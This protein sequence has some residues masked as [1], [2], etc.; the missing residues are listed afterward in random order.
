M[1]RATSQRRSTVHHPGQFTGD[2]SH[3]TGLPAIVSAVARGDCEVYEILRGRAAARSEPV[4]DRQRHHPAG[5]HRAAAASARVSQLHGAARDRF[6]LLAGHVPGARFPVEESHSL[7]V[8]RSGDRPECGSLAQAIRRDGVRYAGGRVRF[9]AALDGIRRTGKSPTRSASISRWR[10]RCTTWWWWAA[11]RRDWRPPSMALPKACGPRCWSIRRRAGR[12]AAACES[13]TTS[14]FPTGLTGSE[15]AGRAI[16]QANK[17]GVHLSVPTLV[18]RL[19][20]ENAY[21]IVHLDGGETVTAKCLLIATGADYRRL[22]VE[23][24]ERFEGTGVY[25]AAT[26]AE[27]QLCEGSQVIVVGGGNSAGQAAV[28]LSGHARQRAAADPRRRSVQE[29]VQLPGAADRADSQHRADL[30]HDH[31]PDERQHASGSVDLVNSKTGR[32]ADGGQRRASSVLSARTRG[33]AGCR[34]KSRGTKRGSSGPERIWRSPHTG[35]PRRQ[36]FLLETS[37]PGVFAAGDVRSGSVKRVASAVGEGAMAV[38]FVHERL[39]H[40]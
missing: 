4:S 13:K 3:V 15:L 22:G 23:G 40:M 31:P 30:Q 18:D 24:S 35:L 16:L 19:S 39:K 27:G 32:G 12:P 14:G 20:F 25:Y 29:H 1:T 34:R 26:L 5:V 6:A 2:I 10:T 37:R 9:D 36:P 21:T 8:D 17:F 28:F 11:G 38:Q 7:H 33:P